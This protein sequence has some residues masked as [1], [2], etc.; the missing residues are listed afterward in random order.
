MLG[1][2]YIGSTYQISVTDVTIE[3]HVCR[4]II[5]TKCHFGDIKAHVRA[6]FEN[7]WWII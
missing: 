3:Q 7:Q 4:Y 6:K 2:A 5:P 1:H